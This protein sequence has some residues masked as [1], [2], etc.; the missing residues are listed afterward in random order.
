MKQLD[1][2]YP[3]LAAQ[4]TRLAA[5]S[6]GP[7]VQQL[8]IAA[9]VKAS[10]AVSR[11]IELPKLIETL[12]TV[13]LENAGADRGLLI[14]PEG[15]GYRV[16]VEAKAKGAGVEVRLRHSAIRETGCPEALVNYAIR[17]KKSVI[18]D[19]GSRPGSLFEDDYLRRGPARSV[20]C[21]PL[22]RQSKLA[23]VLY[24]ENNQATCAFTRDRIAVLEH[25]AAQAAISLE[26]A[27]LY[28]DLKERE[29]RSAGSSMPISS[30]SPSSP[31]TARS[32]RPTRP[33]SPWWDLAA[34][35]CVRGGLATPG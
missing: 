31:W 21:L 17:T 16:E 13:A 28:G 26:N 32:S 25:L 11:E 35:T 6:A 2:H 4:Q 30:A 7:A 9:V 23:G 29:A 3:Q 22:L 33:S 27:R 15:P 14:L 8:D 20:F 5:A 24:L 18:L 19:D 12:M 10:Q 34:M 1:R